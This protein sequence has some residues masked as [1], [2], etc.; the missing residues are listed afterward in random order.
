MEVEE[1]ATMRRR[2]GSRRLVWVLVGFGVVA[3]VA[4]VG[5]V[6]VRNRLDTGDPVVGV[7]NVAVRDNEFGPSAVEVPVG[8]TVTWQWDGK[9]EHNVVGDGLE[10]P[11]QSEGTY[12]YTFDEPGTYEYHCTKHFFMRGEVVV[13]EAG[14]GS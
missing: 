11:L 5:A 14:S 8:T 1:V 6:I 4:G 13:T 9:D 7:S 2:R 3:V 10:S 12:A